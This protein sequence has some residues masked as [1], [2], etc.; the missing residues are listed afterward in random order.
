MVN[1]KEGE[2][3]ALFTRR[4]MEQLKRLELLI[5]DKIEQVKKT[6]I[7]IL[8]LGGVGGYA[9]ESLARSGI[10]KLIIVDS[11][12]IDITNLNKELNVLIQKLL[13]KK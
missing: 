9:V 7:L 3:R 4:V 2:S 10:G 5:G 13:L 1:K 11:D 12:N 8:G 6:T